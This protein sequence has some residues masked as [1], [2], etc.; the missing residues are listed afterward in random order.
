MKKQTNPVAYR[1]AGYTIVEVMIFL[2]VSAALMVPAM[3]L[4]KSKQAETDFSQKARDAQSKIQTWIN[5]VSTGFTGADPS[6]DHCILSAGRP[7]VITNAS[8]PPPATGY[9]PECAYLGEAVQFIDSGSNKSSIYAY[10][11]F[12]SRLNGVLQPKNLK[13][14]HPEPAVGQSGSVNLTQAFDLS[15]LYVRNV[16][17]SGVATA[18]NASHVVG[19]YNSI[20]TEASTTSN[21]QSDVNAYQYTIDGSMTAPATPS[22]ITL[23]SCLELLSPCNTAD[24]PN[25]LNWLHV[26]LTDGK[27]FTQLVITSSSGLGANVTLNY[28]DSLANC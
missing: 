25:K 9:N 12:G 24:Y 23:M 4:I 28:P 27:R 20:N 5:N 2:A 8:S 22:N 16:K 19:F 21:G 3:A 26:C 1:G 15:P 14:S 10:S 11:V 6:Q 7:Q 13:E 18:Y 17:S